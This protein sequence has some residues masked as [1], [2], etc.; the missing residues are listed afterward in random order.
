MIAFA[1]AQT[2]ELVAVLAAHADFVKTILIVSHP[3]RPVLLTG[4]SD[5]TLKVHLLA[6]LLARD[7]DRGG[8]SGSPETVQTLKVHTRPITTLALAP[9]PMTGGGPVEVLSGDSM[10]RVIVWAVDEKEGSVELREV[11]RLKDA[12]T[13]VTALNVCDDGVWTGQSQ[14]FSSSAIRHL[15]SC[16][17]SPCSCL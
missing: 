9:P 4:S 3:T 7:D 1:C 6:P 5:K 14:D 12:Q 15:T 2:G 16:S 10:G 8:L 13:S 17:S 11:R